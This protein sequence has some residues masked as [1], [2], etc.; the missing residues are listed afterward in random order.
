MSSSRNSQ[1]TTLEIVRASVFFFQ[2]THSKLFSEKFW[3]LHLD[4][5]AFVLYDIQ[6]SIGHCSELVRVMKGMRVVARHK[7]DLK[8]LMFL[9]GVD[10]DL[11]EM[12]KEQMKQ[13]LCASLQVYLYVKK[14]LK[15]RNTFYY[16]VLREGCSC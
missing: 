10:D 13:V 14:S 2:L 15:I 16:A 12:A 4:A 11:A 9:T 7:K 6:S 5:K 1:K 8:K 3:T